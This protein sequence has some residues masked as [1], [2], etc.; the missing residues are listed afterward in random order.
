MAGSFLYTPAS[1]TILT[2]GNNQALKVDFT[3]N[4]S[5]NYKTASKT[6]SINVLK[7]TPVITWANPADITYP[8]LLSGT[9]LTATADVAGSFVYTPAAGTKLNASPGQALK[10]D[11]TPT[12]IANYNTA[13]KTVSINVL[14]GTPVITWANP[15]DITYPTLLSG[16]QLNA[17]ADVAGSF[18]YTPA[19]GTKLNA[20]PGQALKVD[21]TPADAANY[22]TATKTVSINVLKGT[23]VITWANPADIVYGT[24]LGAAQLNAT[25]NVP[26]TFTYTPAAGTLLN[27]GPGQ[28]LKVDFT[29][30][31]AANYNTATKTVYINVVYTFI[32]FLAPVDNPPTVNVGNPGR[33]YPVKWQ[34][35]DAN[36]NYV[37]DL[38]SF[39]SLQY[40]SVSCGGFNLN[41]SD[42]LDTTAT[43]GAVLRYDATANQFIYNWQTP[44]TSNACYVLTL[45]LKDGTTHIAD[46]QMKK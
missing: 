45:T 22:N 32:G 38:G 27:P 17:T 10:V 6:V 26:G 13:T 15:A 3:P 23:P 31:D 24:A 8:T 41:L 43:G 25:A 40:T 7:G 14:K 12:D 35:K 9:Q 16:T 28:A 42:P 5:V 46:F 20:N 44:T 1:G 4:D 18:G 19:A 36:G 34:L 37:S 33:T 21:F 11:F 2:A 29:P 30:T 39:A